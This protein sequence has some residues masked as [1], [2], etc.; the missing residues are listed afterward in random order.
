MATVSV[1]QYS[2]K[3]RK[4]FSGLPVTLHALN[5]AKTLISAGAFYALFLA[6]VV[7]LIYPTL[8]N[9]NLSAYLTSNTVAGLVGVKLAHANSFIA[10][11]AI[12]LYGSFYGLLFGGIIAYIAGAALPATIENGT[13]DLALA[14]PVSRTRYYLEM[15]L[16]VLLASLITSVLTVL[17]VWLSSLFV[18]DA[19]IDWSWLITTQLIEF[20]LFVFLVGVG[21]LFGS[22]INA[23]RAAGGTAVGIVGLIYITNAI[24]LLSNNFSW[25][26]KIN[27]FYYAQGAQAL[28][29]HQFTS[30]HP[31]VLVT[32]GLI[33]TL[34]GLF[35]FNRRD[36]PTT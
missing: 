10:L 32:A 36:L 3:A 7:G 23:S 19:G 31:W 21:L 8:A 14:R 35:I 2:S 6:I 18:K 33:C 20:A 16:A 17:A 9:I 27:P 29:Q 22:F 5:N 28:V 15:W 1:P 24:G 34:A 30:W 4:R 12:E 26:L 25:L 13:M 11:I